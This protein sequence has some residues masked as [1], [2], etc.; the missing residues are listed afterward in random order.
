[1][2]SKERLKNKYKTIHEHFTHKDLL[3]LSALIFGLVFS[4][5]SPSPSS[6]IQGVPKQSKSQTEQAQVDTKPIPSRPDRVPSER[7]KKA[8][9]Q[10]KN[11]KNS[12]SKKKRVQLNKSKSKV[13]AVKSL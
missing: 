6:Q 10:L 7:P 9:P 12:I 3:G 8:K 13:T 2:I 5:A 4:G 11:S 1:M